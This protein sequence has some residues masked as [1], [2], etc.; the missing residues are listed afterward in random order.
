MVAGRTAGRYADRLVENKK[1][2]TTASLWLVDW[3]IR[4]GNWIGLGGATTKCHN[5]KGIIN[6]RFAPQACSSLSR[7]D[8][9]RASS[10]G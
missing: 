3:K 6:V 5:A 2:T 9:A 8:S 10:R 4:A 7:G 1:E